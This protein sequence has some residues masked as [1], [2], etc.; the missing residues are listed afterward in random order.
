[1]WVRTVLITHTTVDREWLLRMILHDLEVPHEGRSR[2]ELIQT[3]NEVVLKEHGSGL[4]PPLL[5]I[6]EA[7]NLDDEVLEEV[8]LLT[9]LEIGDTKLLQVILSG[10]PELDRK[11]RRPN[12]RQLGQRIAVRAL[13]GPL[14]PYETGAYVQHRLRVAGAINGDIFKRAALQAV[15]LRTAGVPRLVNILCEQALVN[16]FGAGQSSVTVALVEEAAHDLD[17]QRPREH[18]APHPV[19]AARRGWRS[20]LGLGGRL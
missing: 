17:L 16:A 12:L 20:V 1:V 19:S 15:W 6:D 11:L 4:P 3:L 13:L 10:Q 2:V 7:Q 9:N 14:D 18:G 5:I 8:R